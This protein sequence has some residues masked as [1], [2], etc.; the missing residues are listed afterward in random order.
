MADLVVKPVATRRQREYSWISRG[1][2]TATTPIGFRRCGTTRRSWSATRPHPFYE[3]NRVQ[4][5]LA[6]RGGEVCGRI[7]AILNQGHNDR[8]HEHRGFFGFFECVDDQE[9]ADGLLD[10]VR[11]WFADQGIRR[12]R[13]PTNPSLNYE[14]GTADRRL[15]F[16]A[17]LHDDLQ[18]A[19]L[20]P[21]AGKL[22]LPQDPGPVCLLG[23]HRHAA[24]D[25]REAG[26]G[27]RADHRALQR[28]NSAHGQVAVP[29]RKCR[30]SCRSTIARW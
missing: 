24:E 25:P 7:A 18:P 8:Y 4:T 14:V 26:T 3:R 20:P 22:R 17:H 28:P 1:R 9:V 10:A 19:L 6:V 21:A 23:P 29:G 5:F 27:R 2:C 16:S 15:R 13:G 12:L 30:C 11:Q